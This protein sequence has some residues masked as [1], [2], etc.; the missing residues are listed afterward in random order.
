MKDAIHSYTPRN[1]NIVWVLSS[2]RFPKLGSPLYTLISY[3]PYYD[4]PH[5]GLISS[6]REDP[7]GPTAWL[8]A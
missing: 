4:N 1:Y 2:A 3:N 5:K 8:R 6:V 7:A